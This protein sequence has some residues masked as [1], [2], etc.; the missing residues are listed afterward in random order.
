MPSISASAP[1]KI[2]LLGEH[3]VV[4][5][6]PAIAFPVPA[7]RARAAILANPLGKPGEVEIT[8][9]QVQLQT[10]LD[11][12]PPEHALQHLFTA[13]RQETGINQLPAMKVTISSEIPV[14]AGMGSGAAVSVALLKALGLFIG[15][16]LSSAQLAGM[17]FEAEKAYH[18]N[19]SGIDNTVIAYEKPVYY[20]KDEPIS[21]LT[22]PANLHLLVASSGIP[23]QTIATVSAVRSRMERFPEET[24]AI[25]EHI[26][27]LVRQARVYVETGD[28]TS[29]GQVCMQNHSL[30]MQLGVSTPELDN[31]VSAA[32][33]A[34]ALGAKL[35]GGGG[36]GNILALVDLENQAAVMDSLNKAGAEN[37]LP[38][39]IRKTA[40]YG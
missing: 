40:A 11:Q 12:L 26:G 23:A 3:A 28:A 8:S 30:L 20:K 19:P 17:A 27:A 31:L 10:S 1:A 2:I 5:N 13:F 24:G 37:V 32:V 39:T 29:L 36:G 4:Y 34:G 25:I 18:G 38:A 35:T 6:Q 7:V 16:P 14:A 22:L 33:N 15:L 21:F 9:R